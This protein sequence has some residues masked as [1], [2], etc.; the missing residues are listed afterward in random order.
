MSTRIFFLRSAWIVLLLAGSNLHAEDGNRTTNDPNA[1]WRD[2]GAAAQ[3]PASPVWVRPA[4][5]RA[6]ELDFAALDLLSRRA[7]MEFVS[8]P[9]QALRLALPM[10]DGGFAEFDV[11]ESPVVEPGLARKFP[12][13]RTYAGRGVQNPAA[14]LRFDVTPLGFHAQVLA[15]EGDIFIDPMYA[16][17]NRH[18]AVYFRADHG[19]GDREFRCD[20]HDDGGSS[21]EMSGK[22]ATAAAAKSTLN[23]VG[24]KLRTLRLAMAATSSYTN[25]FGGTVA[26][27][28]AG[29]TTL[30]NRLN[31][32]Y[33]RDL[34]VR[35]VLVENNDLIV[36]TDSNVG[37][38]GAAPTG[39]DT[40]IQTTIDNAIGFANYDL[41][42][43]VG[44]SGSGGAITPLGNVC[45]SSKARGFTSLSPPRGDVFDIDYVAHELGHQLGANHT[46][47]GCGGGGQWT[48]TSAM[49]PGSGSTIMAYAGICPDDL[50]P[51]SDAYFH[52]RS[53][54]QIVTRLALNET[55]SP[56]TCGSNTD[57]GNTAP[58]VSPVASMTI[59]EQTPFQLTAS[60]SDGEGDTLTY[61]WEQTDTAS[62]SASPS[63][64]GDNGT[65]PLFRSYNAT[66]TPTRV[67][68]AMA[69]ILN[70]ANVPPYNI[71]W[72]P[73]SGSAPFYSGEI[74]P[75]PSSGTRL[76]NFRATVRD[77][78]AAGGGVA[79]ATA[80]V[81]AT[82]AAGP[83]VVNNPTGTLAGGSTQAITWAVANTNV[84]PVGTTSVNILVS[85]D[86]GA[87]WSTLA[88]ATANDGSENVTLPNL[89]SA[90]ARFRVEAANGTGVGGGNTWF[91]IT[92]SN[93][94][95]SASGT[96]ITLA[97]GSPIITQQGS[98]APAVVTIATLAGGTAP[99]TLAA[100][101]NPAVSEIEI[102]GLAL[103]G[104]NI[105][106][107]A[108]VSCDLAAPN[109]P[110]YRIYPGVVTAT[111]A[112]GR[113]A[114][115]VFPIQVSNNS[116][117]TLGAYG[118]VV[119]GTSATTSVSP[120]AAPADANNNF[121]AVSVSPTTLPGGG[122]VAVNPATGE[123]TITTT[124]GT[125]L[126][127][128][129]ITVTAVDGCGA[130]AVE[131]FTLTVASNDPVLQYNGNAVTSGNNVIEPNECNTLDV[132]V[133][134]IG[135]GGATAVSAVLSSA[136]PG[137][138]IDQA[139][140]PYPDIAGGG[141]GLNTSAFEISTDNTVACGSTINLTQTMAFT[142]GTGTATL[143]FALQVGQPPATNYSI[144]SDSAAGT[145]SGGTLVAGSQ[146]D[147]ARLA[148]AA[149]PAGFA[150]SIYGT[151]VTSLYASTNGV[152]SFN[153]T[154]GTTSAA[155][156]GAL[157]SNDFSTA[158]LFAF[159]D[160][161]DMSA[162]VTTGGGIYTAINGAAPNRTF[163]IEWRARRYNSSGS[164]APTVQFMIRLHE[165]SNLIETYYTNVTGNNGGGGGNSATVGIQ[166]SAP[167]G[168]TFTQ[169][170]ANTASLSAGQRLAYTRAPGV[171]VTG[172][173]VCFDPN[174]IFKNGFE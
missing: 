53:F 163:D 31:G 9:D 171:C 69:Y 162:G 153:G 147:D 152:L 37:P 122:T 48:Q 8:E 81:T 117:P 107:S 128:Y 167:A 170:S 1:L 125:T 47:F 127:T 139:N 13:M 36:Y 91:D 143:N 90:Q 16:H 124:A 76:M 66:L 41:G 75:N 23:S 89:S 52:A 51:N 20:T 74:L 25:A 151:P 3:Q 95:I 96:P 19:R 113:A 130:A 57:T 99:F 111:D 18:Y 11:V 44:G 164:S 109:L 174:A 102:V 33:E 154:G 39:P 54:T 73:A 84:A 77:N 78:N 169:F 56:P 85:L 6:V 21:A 159:W 131:R 24:P 42:H 168:T 114:S 155:S 80:Q 35:L 145:I 45:T 22:G 116:M 106:A 98:P 49:E 82:S 7:P 61:N 138:T 129:T 79:F 166:T 133:G 93:V 101:P 157:P 172:P 146:D 67:F 12:S 105:Q 46:W 161:L 97:A 119:L 120:G 115:L 26:D 140:A 38:I 72:V 15:P 121:A 141:T 148:V 34:G 5:Y 132:T 32:V 14:T 65:A 87:N 112:A 40:V 63:T 118:N 104:T 136:T 126:G 135:G 50:Q 17:D 92:D 88:A 173:G 68:P 158:A 28:L 62:S 149:F 2:A 160:D 83:F 134:N 103:S 165:T 150:F 60:A 123:V 86:G 110:S 156:N 59:P 64:T 30:V 108:A 4:T 70:N 94:A 71:T 58:T 27:G 10:P 142:G 55:S 144:A 137:V 43:A 100:A 29:L